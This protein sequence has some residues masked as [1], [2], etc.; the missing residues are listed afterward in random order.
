MDGVRSAWTICVA[1]GMVVVMMRAMWEERGGRIEQEARG[2]SCGGEVGVAYMR[3]MYRVL[4]VWTV[5]EGGL[6]AWIAAFIEPCGCGVATLAESLRH[7]SKGTPAT[8]ER[9]VIAPDCG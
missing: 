6:T 2:Y 3:S 4:K 8:I 7:R 5:C 9:A 1:V